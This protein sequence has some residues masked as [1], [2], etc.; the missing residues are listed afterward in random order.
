MRI[1]D[2][3]ALRRWRKQKRYT[4]RELGM[5]VR[6]S[7]TT[8]YAL[9]TGRMKTVTEDLAISIAARLDVPWEELFTAHEDLA[10]PEVSTDARSECRAV[11]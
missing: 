1:K 7:H 6:R 2:P 9:E 10:L 11:S 4:Q 3:A 5:L 8:I